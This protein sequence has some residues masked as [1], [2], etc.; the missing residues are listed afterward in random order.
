MPYNWLACIGISPARSEFPIIKVGY[1]APPYT[2]LFT[3]DE[4]QKIIEAVNA[5]NPDILFVGLTA[6]KQ[7]KWAHKNKSL[8]NIKA[9]CSIGAAFDFYSGVRYRPSKFWR[10]R[11][12]EWLMR[13]FSSPLRFWTRNILSMPIFL[14]DVMKAKINS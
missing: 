13:F 7:E 5:F 11:G 3:E 2:E 8:L 1:H 9:I 14:K 4:N 6:P 10:D 12:L